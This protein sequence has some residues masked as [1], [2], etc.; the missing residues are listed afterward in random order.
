MSPPTPYYE[1]VSDIVQTQFEVDADTYPGNEILVH[2]IIPHMQILW[3]LRR[4]MFAEA[5]RL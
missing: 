2:R 3:E 5:V 4:K 1:V